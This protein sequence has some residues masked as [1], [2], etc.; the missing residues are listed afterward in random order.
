MRARSRWLALLA[1]GS[2]L[3][4]LVASCTDNRGSV[5]ADCLKNQDCVSGV[6]AELVCAAGPTYLDSEAPGDADEEASAQATPD[7]AATAEATAG[8][9]EAAVRDVA[10]EA[11]PDATV[12]A[13]PEAA[14]PP[15]D[16]S[17]GL[18]PDAGAETGADAAESSTPGGEAGTTGDDAESV[19]LL[20]GSTDVAAQA[21]LDGAAE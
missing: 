4:A 20:D 19:S 3:A 2:V 11:A 8:G 13:S 18:P 21:H 15:G 6:C 1:A 5:G 16:G 9:A 10:P 7:G 12:D 17:P 14:P